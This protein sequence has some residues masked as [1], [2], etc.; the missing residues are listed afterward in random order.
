MA[1]RKLLE[2]KWRLQVKWHAGEHVWQTGLKVL[3]ERTR[4]KLL[5]SP[6]RGSI[7]LH[8][9]LEQSLRIQAAHHY[10]RQASRKA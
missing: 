2:L 9:A 1:A 3:A 8:S 10:G 4:I 5:A 7:L 6:D